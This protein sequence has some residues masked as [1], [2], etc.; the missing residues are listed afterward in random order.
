M[1]GKVFFILLLTNILVSFERFKPD[2]PKISL[3]VSE[4]NRAERLY[5]QENSN[6]KTDSA[7]LLA[8]QDVLAELVNQPRYVLTDSLRYQSFYK[9][10]V[11]SEVYKQYGQATDL[12]LQA[13]SY[14][15]T[16]EQ[17]IRMFVF[18]GAG[19]YN[20]NNFDSASFFL[21]S[22]EE[23]SR[24]LTSTDDRMRLYN[25]LGVLYYD[26]GN[27][28]ES[29]NYFTQALRLTKDIK[30]IQEQNI[31]S[32][33]LNMAI[34]YFKLGLFEKALEL[35]HEIGRYKMLSDELY[36]NMGI[37]YSRTQRY[38]E[39]I[40]IFKKVKQRN[41]PGVLNEMARAYMESGKTD[42]AL[43]FINRY[44]FKKKILAANALEDGINKQYQGDLNLIRSIPDSALEYYQQA[45]ILLSK[46]F[47]NPDPRVNPANFTGSFAY[48][49]I[50][51]VLD[52]KAAAWDLLYSKTN[53]P[54]DLKSAF[55]T[56]QSTISLLSYIEKSYETDDAKIF[57]KEKM[58][59]VYTQALNVCLKLDK[60]FPRSGYLE[61]AFLITEKNKASVMSAEI[62][63]KNFAGSDTA[64]RELLQE[65]RNIRYNLARLNAKTDQRLTADELNH[66]NDE[67]SIYESRLVGVRRKMEENKKFY[68]MK[69]ADDFPTVKELQ[70][71]LS[72]RQALISFYNTRD[73]I[74]IFVLKNTSLDHVRL[75]N[76]NQIRDYLN[77]WIEMM[78]SVES[79][80]KSHLSE[81]RTP[82]FQDLVKPITDLAGDQENWIIIPDGLF[83][84]LSFESLPG[85]AEGA[86]L[87]E[88]HEI[89]YEFSARFIM[90]SNKSAKTF[91]KRDVLSFAPFSENSA[92][93]DNE[94]MGYFA[95]LTYSKDE[96][97]GLTGAQY[98]DSQ[99]TKAIFIKNLNH[100]SI[101]HL[102]THAVADLD[103]PSSSFVAFFPASGLRSEDFLFQ[104]ELY[105]LT[106]D[107]CQL[108]VISA[109]ETGQGKLV[110]DEGVMS[111]ARA[112][113]YAGCPSTINTLW[114]ADDQST[115]LI[116][117]GFYHYL[118]KG[119]SKSTALRRAK[120]DFIHTHPIYRN[121]A[122]W[123]H[124][125]LTGN[126]DALY[127]K[128]RTWPGLAFGI[129][130]STILFF[131][132]QGIR[133]KADVFHS[134]ILDNK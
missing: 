57:L 82:I 116:I 35:Y 75:K 126:P 111:F 8:Y 47:T 33:E 69:Y 3:I 60:L 51:D 122:Y 100:Y 30:P 9:S 98:I 101:L 94:G 11:L 44:N 86:P 90:G 104:E 61:E 20:Q 22:A 54:A 134:K 46:N 71:H 23:N 133:K 42:S 89:S 115:A 48:L 91:A 18:A 16:P 105:G 67:V 103:N 15:S 41:F 87:I 129:C 99:A 2:D 88:Q 25:T 118:E 7:S 64:G 6:G 125:V 117:K 72:G 132:V 50:F 102:A 127:E 21:L 53:S 14:A 95:K 49:R 96:I 1:S 58:G 121:P 93:L 52:K 119:Y 78:Q 81:I 73:A 85:D 113:L 40:D 84:L 107:S 77:R 97:S 37:T 36:M 131:A 27:F 55:D 66:L 123:A 34:C 45:L 43:A 24:S 62:K 38:T 39:A 4:F 108:V 28:L 31:V 124:L 130:F 68:Q 13:V 120:L 109:C 92:H 110:S 10:G 83:F 70:N 106:M 59:T 114:K 112:F 128:K 65:E 76:G 12:Y 5:N 56:Y 63:Q 79:G 17:K 32:I 19:Y 29:K 80:H 74:E 26:N